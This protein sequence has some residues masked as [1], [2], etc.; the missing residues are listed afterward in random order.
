[1]EELK[2]LITLV[3][4]LPAMAIWLLV[5]F[6]GY[7]VIIAG[8]I[9]GVIRFAINRLHSWATTPKEELTRYNV[10]G[11]IDGMTITK[12]GA[13]EALLAQ[14]NRLRGKRVGFE[15]DYIH[16]CSVAWLREAIDAKEAADRDKAKPVAKAV[17]S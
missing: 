3:K 17:A 6:Y 10:T 14:L 8:S 7:K 2:L 16:E 13:H 4:D 1:M 12:G 5:I 11:Q 9:Y 15:S